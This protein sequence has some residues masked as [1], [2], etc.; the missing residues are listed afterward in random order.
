MCLAAGLV[1][2]QRNQE[3]IVGISVVPKDPPLIRH[4]MEIGAGGLNGQTCV[5]NK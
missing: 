5:N 4:A 1:F 2:Q 3:L